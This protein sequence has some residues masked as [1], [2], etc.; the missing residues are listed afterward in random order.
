MKKIEVIENCLNDAKVQME[1]VVDELDQ[2]HNASNYNLF[3][4]LCKRATTIYSKITQLQE[5]VADL[6][7][8]KL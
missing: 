3:E 2:A 6:K 4:P 7:G 1:A 8:I 5:I